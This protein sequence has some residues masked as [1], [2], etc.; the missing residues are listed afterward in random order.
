MICVPFSWLLGCALSVHD[1]AIGSK[2]I[3][4]DKMIISYNNKGGIFQMDDLC[5]LGYTYD[6]S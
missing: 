2:G 3:H 6:F 4:V 5:D 1:Q